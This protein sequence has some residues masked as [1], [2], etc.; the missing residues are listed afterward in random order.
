MEILAQA[1]APERLDWFGYGVS[2]INR[3]AAF[4]ACAIIASW[5]IA[6]IP[7][8]WTFWI[9]LIV[10]LALFY[11]LVQTQSRGAFVALI[12]SI[13]F[14]GT[15]VKIDFTRSRIIALIF[16]AL[17]AGGMFFQS[18]FSKRMEN[19]IALESSSA[20]CRADIYVSGL[21]MFTD[22]P[23][24]LGWTDKAIDVYKRWYQSPDDSENYISM[25]N[26]HL[27]FMCPHGVVVKF[28]YLLF[29]GFIFFI[30]FPAKRDTLNAVFFSTWLCFGL[31]ACFSNVMNYWVLWIIPLTLLILALW[32]NRK[33]LLLF[34]FHFGIFAFAGLTL[35]ALF[36]ISAMLPR[37]CEL[38]FLPHGEVMVGKNPEYLLLSPNERSVGISYGSE[39]VEFC[40]KNNTSALVS[41]F[42][43]EKFFKSVIICNVPVSQKL[44][45]LK[46]E[47]IS[48]LNPLFIEGAEFN[49]SEKI[50]VYLGR[51]SDW[52]NRKAWEKFC[53]NNKNVELKIL[54]GVA[55]YVP[56]WTEYFNNE[57]N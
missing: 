1:M 53:E 43:K 46:T 15:R 24:G 48:I 12:V 40:I 51:L 21:K 38:K 47:R 27:E 23:D 36:I 55:N 13:I 16:T 34:R 31:C 25:I 56:D 54:E 19:M 37:K 29:W 50:Q 4:I 32:H 22:A 10:S 57:N 6:A 3:T 35:A 11:F 42:V 26:S 9:S 44:S 5:T 41:N 7:R 33:R 52:R 2:S 28:A 49:S 20:N 39:L 18:S 14:F 30:T 45:D 17:F 8:K